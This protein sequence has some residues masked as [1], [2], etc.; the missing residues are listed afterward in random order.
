MS[1]GVEFGRHNTGR[2]RTDLGFRLP[3]FFC[4]RRG[5]AWRSYPLACERMGMV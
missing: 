1:I 4:C 3:R 2:A 5:R